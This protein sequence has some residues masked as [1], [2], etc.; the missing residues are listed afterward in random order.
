MQNGTRHVHESATRHICSR[1]RCYHSW[2]LHVRSNFSRTFVWKISRPSF[3]RQKLEKL[4]VLPNMEGECTSGKLLFIYVNS[5]SWYVQAELSFHDTR[6]L[7]CHER[8]Y[9][10]LNIA[11]R[12]RGY[13]CKFMVLL[14]S[15]GKARGRHLQNAIDTTLRTGL[16]NGDSLLFVLRIHRVI[17]SHA[18]YSIQLSFLYENVY[19]MLGESQ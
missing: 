1:S 11:I 16:S 4:D 18:F 7:C 2:H 13:L 10:E 12:A 8:Y 6:E 15:E 17:V 5:L 14:R 9:K 19:R 3:H